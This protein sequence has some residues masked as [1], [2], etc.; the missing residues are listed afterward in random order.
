MRL[1]PKLRPK[2]YSNEYKKYCHVLLF[3]GKL[4][5]VFLKFG[6]VWILHFKILEFGFYLLKLYF[7]ALLLIFS[8]K[9]HKLAMLVYF[10]Q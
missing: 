9:C 10:I 3:L 7:I 8:L 4:Q 5:T 6:D 2:F 1:R